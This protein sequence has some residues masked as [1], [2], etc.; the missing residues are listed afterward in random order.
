MEEEIKKQSDSAN[1][2][3]LEIVKNQKRNIKNLI[4]VFLTAI[5]CYTVILVTLI[6]GFLWYES[7]FEFFETS[8]ITQEVDGENSEINNVTGDMYRDNSVHNEGK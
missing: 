2:L 3:L 6:C 7:Q 1:E 5:I 8:T 4:K